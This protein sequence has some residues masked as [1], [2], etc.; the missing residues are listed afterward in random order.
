MYLVRFNSAV[1]LSFT[2]SA[3]ELKM[4]M[5]PNV[6][7][8]VST[9]QYTWLREAPCAPTIERVSHLESRMRSFVANLYHAKGRL[10]FYAGAGGYG[11]QLMAAAVARY[12]A[13]LGYEVTV[14]VDP[15]NQPCWWNYPFVRATVVLPLS[16]EIFRAFDHHALFEIVTNVD[17]HPDQQHPV[18]ALL[19]RMGVDPRAVPPDLKVAPPV[20][21]PDERAVAVRFAQDNRLGLYQ[22]G[23]SGENRRLSPAAS[24]AL[25]MQVAER[26]PELTWLGLY[27]AHIHGDFY[28]ALPSDAPRNLRLMTFP[29]IRQLFAVAELAPVGVGPDSLLAHVMG[30]NGRPFVGLWGPMRPSLR[31]RYYPHHTPIWNSAACPQA[32]CFRYKTTLDKCPTA[33]QVAGMCLCL[34]DVDVDQVVGAVRSSLQ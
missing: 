14:A 31:V 30:A 28:A 24:R 26:V 3:A 20:L 15:G 12:L 10:L 27:D 2:K 17:Q 9:A 34:K 8:V 21:T 16:F 1:D 19:Y 13:S 7:Y 4:V 6:D 29:S 22:L 11:D 18:D 33:A 23:G 5:E 25:L 32:P